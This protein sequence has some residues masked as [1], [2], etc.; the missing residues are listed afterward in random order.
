MQTALLPCRFWP[1]T[2]SVVEKFLGRF[3]GN[4]Y[5]ALFFFRSSSFSFLETFVEKPKRKE[6]DCTCSAGFFLLRPDLLALAFLLRIVFFGVF[7]SQRKRD[8]DRYREKERE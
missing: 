7:L 5:L 6:A 4:F 8:R 1:L 2:F 3:E